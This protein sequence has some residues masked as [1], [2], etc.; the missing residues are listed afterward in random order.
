[1]YQAAF[2]F[3]SAE[4]CCED[5]NLYDLHDSEGRV[6]AFEINNLGIGPKPPRWV[7][8]LVIV[9][10]AFLSHRVRFSRRQIVHIV[11]VCAVVAALAWTAWAARQAW[12]DIARWS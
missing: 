4:D 1:M 5:M 8:Q 7:P 2:C 10:Q 12:E 6:F 3:A 9:R 11:I